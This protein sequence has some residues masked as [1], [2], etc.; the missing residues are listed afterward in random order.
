MSNGI[1]PRALTQTDERTLAITWTD[2]REDRFDVVA[3]RRACPC[4]SC[5][6]EWTRKAILKPE[7]VPETVRPTRIETVGAYAL[8]IAFNDGHSTGIY[9]FATLRSGPVSSPNRQ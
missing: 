5:K 2:G 8:K 4:A 3:L 7:D 9:T 6:D 1:Q